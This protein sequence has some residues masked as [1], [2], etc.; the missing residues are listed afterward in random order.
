VSHVHREANCA[1]HCLAK[2]ALF[3]IRE[4]V[5][6]EDAPQGISDI[7]IAERCVQNFSL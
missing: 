6:V 7:V 2:L 1:A 4:V 5:Y 3:S